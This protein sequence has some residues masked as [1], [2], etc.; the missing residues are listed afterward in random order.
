[1]YV[2]V[3]DIR[4]SITVLLSD[5]KNF[6]STCIILVRTGG[7]TVFG[8]TAMAFLQS[9][10]TI[11]TTMAYLQKG[12]TVQTMAYLQNIVTFYTIHCHISYHGTSVEHCNIL[13]HG[14]SFARF[15][16]WYICRTLLP[17]QTCS[18]NAR[19]TVALYNHYVSLFCIVV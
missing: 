14:I 2:H 1:M 16:P 4:I 11:Q 5:N 8:K 3:A 18:R 15:I 10:A 19:Y 17:S 7:Q 9:V 13:Y 12:A 6:Y